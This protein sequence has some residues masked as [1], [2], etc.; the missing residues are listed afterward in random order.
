MRSPPFAGIFDS[1][2]YERK[3]EGE[4]VLIMGDPFTGMGWKD[5]FMRGDAA[6]IHWLHHGGAPSIGVM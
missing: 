3:A 4:R 6:R 2:P 1:W 5:F